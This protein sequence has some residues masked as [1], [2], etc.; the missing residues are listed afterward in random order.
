VRV[1]LAR[2]NRQPRPRIATFAAWEPGC[3]RAP[4]IF[5]PAAPAPL[6]GILLQR[7][8][9]SAIRASSCLNPEPRSFDVRR[10]ERNWRR[11][12][13]AAAIRDWTDLKNPDDFPTLASNVSAH[14]STRNLVPTGRHLLRHTLPTA[15]AR[16]RADFT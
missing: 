15:A 1:P 5:F 4:K 10:Q 14:P 12:Q 2:H 11:R 13:F 16:S 6:S 9:N 7:K 8:N 3:G